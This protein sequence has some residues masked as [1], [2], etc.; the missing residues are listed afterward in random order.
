LIENAAT[1]NAIN[2]HSD[3]MAYRDLLVPPLIYDRCSLSL[4]PGQHCLRECLLEGEKNYGAHALFAL[5]PTNAPDLL[6]ETRVSQVK[7]ASN[8]MRELRV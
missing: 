4:Q 1:K 6:P 5:H 8:R 2:R 3:S 7:Y